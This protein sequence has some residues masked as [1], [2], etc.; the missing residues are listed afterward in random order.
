MAEPAPSTQHTSPRG[1]HRG[2]GARPRHN[3]SN[4]PQD[5]ESSSNRGR[6]GGNRGRGSRGGRNRG[7]GSMHDGT[8]LPATF[9]P[10]SSADISSGRPPGGGFGARLTGAASHV[11]GDSTDP[12]PQEPGAGS[13]DAIGDEVEVCFI[14]ASPIVHISIAPC[15]H[16]TCH[17]CSL[18]LR[19]LYKTRAC[20]HCRV[21]LTIRPLN[22]N[23][24]TENRQRR[25][26]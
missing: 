17:I 16:Q 26:S 2:R 23:K 1:S 9:S 21:S 25:R 11:Q 24:L 6:G 15:N 20:A 8:S 13:E 12:Q 3:A 22:P 4:D 7:R 19:A 18:R 5:H 14:C 10:E